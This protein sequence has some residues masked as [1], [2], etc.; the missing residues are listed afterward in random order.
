LL[1]AL[2]ARALGARVI[3][4]EVNTER[5]ASA[6]GL[7]FEVVD[8]AEQDLAAYVAGATDN[9]GAD[10]VFEVS[11][12]AAAAL[13]MTELAALRGRLV[14]VAIYPEPQPLKLLDFFLK[15]LQLRGARV[16]EPEDYDR[17]IGMIS[18]GSLPLH[19][20]ISRVEPLERAPRLFEEMKGG[21][22]GL[23]I[24]VDCRL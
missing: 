3:L 17:A 2:V 21:P 23:K 12:S 22:S 19:Q 8:V 5:L 7:G 4:S 24:L 10:V 9:R 11:G 15:E 1:I 6:A 20:L 13:S 18:E 14:V 16:Y